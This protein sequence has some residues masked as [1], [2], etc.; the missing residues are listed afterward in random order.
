MVVNKDIDSS[1]RMSH[2]PPP[3]PTDVPGSSTT[4]HHRHRDHDHH[5]HR[6][7]LEEMDVALSQSLAS[8]SIMSTN[9]YPDWHGMIPPR[10]EKV[11]EVEVE[12]EEADD[13]TFNLDSPSKFLPLTEVK[14]QV[15]PEELVQARHAVPGSQATLIVPDEPVDDEEMKFV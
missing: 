6:D 3:P 8:A 10:E 4:E 14:P 9:D 1:L 15:P 5:H 13:D 7:H 2:A 12:V 11:E